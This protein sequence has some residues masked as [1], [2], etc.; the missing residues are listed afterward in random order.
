LN[1]QDGQRQTAC[2]RYISAR[3]QRSQMTFSS[4]GGFEGGDA[5]IGGGLTGWA[6]R[7]L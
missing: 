1:P 6:I 5:T 2:I 4:A 3:P 7:E